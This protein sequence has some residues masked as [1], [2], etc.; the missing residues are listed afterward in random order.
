MI[1]IKAKIYLFKHG[2][3]V[4]K[5]I[6]D[7]YRPAFR[8]EN[9]EIYFSGSIQLTED[10]VKVQSGAQEVVSIY[11]NRNA[12]TLDSIKVGATFGIYEPPIKFGEGEVLS[13]K[14]D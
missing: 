8:F 10:L 3:T 2:E 11:F 7:K 1:E 9:N 4:K 12:A 6:L 14:V 5:E 13:V